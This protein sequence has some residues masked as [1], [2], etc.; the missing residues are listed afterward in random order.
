METVRNL[1]VLGGAFE[2]GASRGGGL[3]AGLETRNGTFKRVVLGRGGGGI[4]GVGIGT[5]PLPENVNARVLTDT[6]DPVAVR[7][8]AGLAGDF[9]I[10][11]VLAR[12]ELNVLV[13]SAADEGGFLTTEAPP[14]PTGLGVAVNGAALLDV[15]GVF[16]PTVVVA[17]VEPVRFLDGPAS[18]FNGCPGFAASDVKR[19][20]DREVEVVNGLISALAS[21]AVDFAGLIVRRAVVEAR[22][23]GPGSADG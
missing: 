15:K 2:E 23:D 5:A 20:A 12:R 4:G 17:A 16:R 21:V 19:G 6:V 1:D 13:A 10:G 3:G 14:L 11:G 7:G 18:A 9:T 8:R 22:L